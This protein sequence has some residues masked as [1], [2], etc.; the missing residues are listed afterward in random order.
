MKLLSLIVLIANLVKSQV[1]QCSILS[2]DKKTCILF[3]PKYKLSADNK[4]CI[5]NVKSCL[6]Y[7]SSQY[8][9]CDVC[10]NGY[11]SQK[12]KNATINTCSPNFLKVFTKCKPGFLLTPGNL[13]LFQMDI[14]L[15]LFLIVY[16]TQK[17]YLIIMETRNVKIAFLHIMLLM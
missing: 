2:A 4:K 1:S 13:K 10:K 14:V 9:S 11:T 8:T 12:L 17:H 3:S 16:N 5:E 7:T 6:T 15:S